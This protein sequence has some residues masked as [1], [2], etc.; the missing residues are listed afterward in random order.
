L[1]DVV[2]AGEEAFWT[3]GFAVVAGVL[4]FALLAATTWA[5]TMLGAWAGTF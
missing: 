5:A 4:V 2:E 3:V 1:E